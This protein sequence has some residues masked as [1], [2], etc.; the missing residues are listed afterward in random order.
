M[1]IMK[2]MKIL[3][4]SRPSCSSWLALPS[5][6]FMPS[7]SSWLALP[8]LTFMPFMFFMVSSPEPDLQA[9]HALHG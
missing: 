9:L 3:D 1:K 5:L 2:S 6:I 4:D 8:S 7:C